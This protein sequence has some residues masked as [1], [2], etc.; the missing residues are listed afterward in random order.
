MIIENSYVYGPRTIQG[1]NGLKVDFKDTRTPTSDFEFRRNG[2]QFFRLDTALDN[3]VY[4]RGIVAGGGKNVI[5]AMEI[6]MFFLKG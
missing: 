5:L 6:E 2:N 1:Q 3:V 4:L